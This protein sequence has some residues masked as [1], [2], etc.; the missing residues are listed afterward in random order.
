MSVRNRED[1]SLVSDPPGWQAPDRLH[2]PIPTS[3][4][5]SI[6]LASES[7]LQKSKEDWTLREATLQTPTGTATDPTQR[8]LDPTPSHLH[9]L[10]LALAQSLWESVPTWSSKTLYRMSRPTPSLCQPPRPPTASTSHP[11]TSTVLTTVRIHV[12]NA[13]KRQRTYRE[14]SAPTRIKTKT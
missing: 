9:W 2:P 3:D 6:V 7:V 4:R 5:V 8:I 1:S 14:K 12:E 11:T 10:P 13:Q